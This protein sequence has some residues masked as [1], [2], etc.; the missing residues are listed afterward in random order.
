MFKTSSIKAYFH[1]Q[2]DFYLEIVAVILLQSICHNWT[3]ELFVTA[4]VTTESAISHTDLITVVPFQI[5]L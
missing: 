5:V 2:D 4:D 3:I 1:C